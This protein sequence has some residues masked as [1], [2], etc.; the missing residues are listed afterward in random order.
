MKADDD[1]FTLAAVSEFLWRH[2][3]L[4]A[5]VSI[6]FTVT[7]GVLAFRTKPYFRAEVMVTEVRERGMGAMGSLASQ[8]GGL[9]SLAGVNLTAGGSNNQ[10]AAA[11]LES[12]HLAEEFIKRNE[13]LPELVRD[14]PERATL[15][16]AVKKFKEGVLTI[17][18]DARKGTTSVGVQW[19]DPAQAA[20]LANSYV[21]LANEL[22]RTRALDESHRNINYLTEQLAHTEAV[23]L[24]KVMYNLI[25]N[26]T[27]NLMIANG[28]SEYAFEVVDPAVAPELKLGPHRLFICLIGLMVGFAFAAALAFAVE[29]IRRFRRVNL[30]DALNH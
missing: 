2:R 19:N 5:V 25:E 21:A 9:A 17:R 24:R 4:I 28:R 7:A 13:L 1:D 30:A 10:E 26:E 22:I 16:M 14:S 20:R 23:D 15:W 29:R 8:L 3:L 11:I 27:K 12:R 6:V 18:K